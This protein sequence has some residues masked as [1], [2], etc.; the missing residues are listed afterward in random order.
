LIENRVSR[1]IFGHKREEVTGNWRKLHNEELNNLYCSPNIVPGMKPKIIRWAGRVAR[2]GRGEMCTVFWWGNLRE[3][4][5]RGDPGVDG[6]IIIRWI[7][8][9]WDVRGMDWIQLAQDRESWLSSVNAVM[10][11]RVL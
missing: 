10:N 6:R 5:H 9:K 8:R 7:F 4:G 11:F 2:V 3:R 1:T